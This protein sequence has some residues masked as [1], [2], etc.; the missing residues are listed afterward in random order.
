ME[1]TRDFRPRIKAVDLFCGAGGLTC[2]LSK[3]GI[4]VV[5]G[6][7]VDSMCRF[8]FEANSTA[9]F[10]E[11]DITSLQSEEISEF[12][13]GADFTVLAGCAPCQP[14]SSYSRSLNKRKNLKDTRWDLLSSFSRL[15]EEI[16]PD[17]VTMENV[18]GLENQSVFK[19]FLR[20]LDRKGYRVDYKLIF[21]PDYGLAQT[22]RRLVLVAGQNRDIVIPKASF[23]KKNYRNVEDVIKHLPPIKAGEQHKCDPLHK[24]SR[25][26]TVNLQRI[27]LS[28]PGGTW[29]DWP[30]ELRAN[31]HEKKSGETYLG[32][33]GR[34]SWNQPAPTMTTQC[35]GYGNGRFGHPEQDRAISLREAALLQSFPESYKFFPPGEKFTISSV[36]RMIGNAVPV[37]IGEIVGTAILNSLE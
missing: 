18:P 20:M 30:K 19:E 2:G 13:K 16:V 1:L 28:R 33:Y 22:R 17:F 11:K 15:V 5:A 37:V 8:P 10:I 25:L 6:V 21:C 24:S 27:K 23:S 4:D 14:F 36:A 7:D 12:F 32:V 34:M 9:K 31:C 3:V 29:L 26:S 35:N